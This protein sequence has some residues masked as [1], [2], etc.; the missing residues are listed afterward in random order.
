MMTKRALSVELVFV[1]LAAGIRD[2]SGQPRTPQGTCDGSS[3]SEG[4]RIRSVGAVG[5]RE[6]PDASDAAALLQVAVQER[7]N[8]H[9]HHHQVQE[10]RSHGSRLGGLSR[11]ERGG[12]PAESASRNLVVFFDGSG[13]HLDATCAWMHRPDA[14]CETNIAQLWRLAP[15]AAAGVADA[16][17][18]TKYIKGVGVPTEYEYFNVIRQNIDWLKGYGFGIGV[19]PN[20]VEAYLWL[21]K[22]YKPGDKLFVFG[23]SRGTISARYL[24]GLLHRVGLAKEGNEAEALRLHEQ[25]QDLATQ[26][27]K[28]SEKSRRGVEV[29]FMGLFEAVLRTLLAP[30]THSDIRKF[31]LQISPV[32]RNLYHAI[33][34]SDY[35]ETFQVGELVVP[36]STNAQQAWFM[37]VHSDVGGGYPQLEGNVAH[38][39][40]SWLADK[41]VA[42]GLILAEGW[43]QDLRLDFAGDMGMLEGPEGALDQNLLEIRNP[44]HCRNETGHGMAPVLVH[45]SVKDRM[46]R[47]KGWVPLSV[48]C[49]YWAAMEAH[50]IQWISNPTYDSGKRPVASDPVAPRWVRV[51]LGRLR[52]V[53][54]SDEVISTP[55]YYV[56]VQV[57]HRKQT[58]GPASAAEEGCCTKRTVHPP[59]SSKTTFTYVGPWWWR[60]TLG[61]VDF[62]RAEVILPY[63]VMRGDS[64][65]V[66]VHEDDYVSD[67]FVGRVVLPYAGE[68][69]ATTAMGSRT[70]SGAHVGKHG[71]SLEVEVEY[72]KEEDVDLKG[73]L[74]VDISA[75]RHF[76][77]QENADSAQ[78]LWAENSLGGSHVVGE[79]KICGASTSSITNS[80]AERVGFANAATCA[81]YL[82]D[83]TTGA[84]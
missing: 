37:G 32:V 80:V 26:A 51:K 8:H 44:L 16:P 59:S 6:K 60:T 19:K 61:N 35:R 39:P 18:L 71:A 30:F 5:D 31:H 79:L 46:E 67:D 66:E 34:L 58:L 38:I 83:V 13:N 47:L 17:Q 3:D 50:G 48:C 22:N 33:G 53:P 25:D 76:A 45:Q 56:T 43:A 75:R 29:E 7:R 57:W 9:H 55:S 12:Q 70:L 77:G 74:N 23:Y 28:A 54:G 40:M 82:E 1:L 14:L 84:L 2:S 69:V 65:L 64:V 78:C 27:F 63:H 73:H 11:E 72:L 21:V 68:G 10:R 62:A 42:H 4:C 15:H 36:E 52:N 20:A 24:Q 49:G 41:A 81:G